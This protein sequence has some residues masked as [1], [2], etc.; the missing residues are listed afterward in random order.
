MKKIHITIIVFFITLSNVDG[1]RLGIR[2][3]L[4]IRNATDT[5]VKNIVLG[6]D[7]AYMFRGR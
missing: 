7:V 3:G 1:Q 5:S 2:G 6:I 4:D